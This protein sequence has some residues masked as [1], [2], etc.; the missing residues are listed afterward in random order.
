MAGVGVPLVVVVTYAGAEDASYTAELVLAFGPYNTNA[1]DGNQTTTF[2]S[3]NFGTSARGQ[4]PLEDLATVIGKKPAGV[5]F[6]I[7]G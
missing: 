5:T 1:N 4:Q 6:T 3:I 2:P 7:T